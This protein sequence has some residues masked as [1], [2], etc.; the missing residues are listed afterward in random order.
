MSTLCANYDGS[1]AGDALLRALIA[2]GASDVARS[3]SESRSSTQVCPPHLRRTSH[4][5]L[6][7]TPED[8]HSCHVCNQMR[9]II[10]SACTGAGVS[11]SEGCHESSGGQLGRTGGEGSGSTQSFPPLSKVG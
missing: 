8:M 11:L 7:R 4:L 9:R 6:H 10:M 1:T 3:L 2:C 5:L